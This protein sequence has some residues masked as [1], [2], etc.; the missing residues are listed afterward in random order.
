MGQKFQIK[1]E[2]VERGPFLIIPETVW[3]APNLAAA[4]GLDPRDFERE[5]ISRD[6]LF[7]ARPHLCHPG[8]T[9]RFCSELLWEGDFATLRHRLD[10]SY[11]CASHPHSC[12]GGLSTFPSMKTSFVALKVI[13]SGGRPWIICS[14]LN[15]FNPS[16]SGGCLVQSGT[17]QVSSPKCPISRRV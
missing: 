7:W 13:V 6:F 17:S 10:F 14:L 2:T 15:R 8:M 12:S 3:G 9:D 1:P 5:I 4:G 16:T 11:A